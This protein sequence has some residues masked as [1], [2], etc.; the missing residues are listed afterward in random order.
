MGEIANN[1][2]STCDVP[3]VF[4]VLSKHLKRHQGRYVLFGSRVS[5]KT[6]ETDK[7]GKINLFFKKVTQIS[8]AE[9]AKKTNIGCKKINIR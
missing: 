3:C 8:K 1:Q 5:P 6:R 2:G 9:F 4:H 7:L